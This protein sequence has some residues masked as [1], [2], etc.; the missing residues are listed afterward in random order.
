MLGL[1]NVATNGFVNGEEEELASEDVYPD[2]PL[3]SNMDSLKRVK[4]NRSRVGLAVVFLEW[5]W[6]D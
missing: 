5:R 2:G 1:R 3:Q 4:K 6:D